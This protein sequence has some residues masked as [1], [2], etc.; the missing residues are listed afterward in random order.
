MAM[1]V[2]LDAGPAEQGGGQVRAVSKRW[3]AL[4]VALAAGWGILFGYSLTFLNEDMPFRPAAAALPEPPAFGFPP[5]P[6]PVVAAVQ[7]PTAPSPS[8]A[9]EPQA[10]PVAAAPM[11]APAPVPRMD[12]AEYVGTWGPTEAACGRR[13]RRRGYIPATITPDRASAG[14]TICSFHDGRRTG[15]AWVM[16]ADC[17]DRGRRWSSQVRLVV[18]GDRLTWTSGKG[19]A[20]YVRCGRR[21]G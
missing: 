2:G 4:F 19:T 16:A 13:S 8:V 9:V 10:A 1:A 5:L 14:R 18:D 11:P 6:Q 21:A 12:R 15:N 7:A 3:I 20:S 17:A